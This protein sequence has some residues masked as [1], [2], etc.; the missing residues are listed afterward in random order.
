MIRRRIIV[1][2][3]KIVVNMGQDLGNVFVSL[4][5]TPR[6]SMS[7]L[8]PNDASLLKN[9]PAQCLMPTKEAVDLMRNAVQPNRVC[10]IPLK[11]PRKRAMYVTQTLVSH[12]DV[13]TLFFSRTDQMQTQR[14]CVRQ[15][16]IARLKLDILF[17]S[18]IR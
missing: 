14:N 12:H 4:C 7:L 8:P 18:I 15:I 17:V 9:Y 10:K 6:I 13:L 5:G 2:T 1:K 16:V 3:R 11:R